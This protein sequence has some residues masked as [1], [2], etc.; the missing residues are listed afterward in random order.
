MRYRPANGHLDAAEPSPSSA[1]PR[2]PSARTPEQGTENNILAVRLLWPVLS[3]QELTGLPHDAGDPELRLP[4][5]GR[6]RKHPIHH[7]SNPP[8]RPYQAYRTVGR[9]CMIFPRKLAASYS[10]AAA[11]SKA[12]STNRCVPVCCVPFPRCRGLNLIQNSS[13]MPTS[14]NSRPT[15]CGLPLNGSALRFLLALC[16]CRT[17]LFWE[18]NGAERSTRAREDP[19]QR[20]SPERVMIAA[21]TAKAPR[22]DSWQRRGVLARRDLPGDRSPGDQPL[23]GITGSRHHR[24]EGCFVCANGS[25]TILLH[26]VAKARIGDLGPR[27]RSDP[28][29]EALALTQ[30]TVVTQRWV[31]GVQ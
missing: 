7:L 12:A 13:S 15:R 6:R 14:A 18:C 31:R 17:D 19:A 1:K 4:D 11:A 25:G 3:D 20:A 10:Y 27:K 8:S 16:S 23:L 22:P 28:P 26:D 2:S 21:P 29:P 9:E 30:K 24:G 5:R